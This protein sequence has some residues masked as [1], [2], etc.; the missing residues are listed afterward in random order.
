VKENFT[1]A[2]QF[3]LRW[4]GG[5]DDDPDDP[6]GR[7]FEGIT[8]T[9][10]DA[11]CVLKNLLHGDVWLCPQVTITDIYRAS[12]WNPYCDGLPAGVDLMFFD[13]AVNEGPREAVLF[14]QRAL[15]IKADG[16]FG[17]VTAAI[18]KTHILLVRLLQDMSREREQHY[19]SLPI[20][21]RKLAKFLRGWLN[22][23]VDCLETALK[24]TG[25]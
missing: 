14:L 10:Y 7:T 6:G 1:A 11:W 21:N 25:A 24:L 15:G 3:V 12:Y 8:Q 5:K 18:L 4:E 17:V 22:R 9:E 13:V 2:L 19:R 23:N 16:H 20:R